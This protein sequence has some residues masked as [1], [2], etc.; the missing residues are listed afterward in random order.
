[1]VEGDQIS[2]LLAKRGWGIT[3]VFDGVKAS[4][5]GQYGFSSPQYKSISGIK[6]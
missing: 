2:P 4:V 3:L 5:K 1:M 6:W